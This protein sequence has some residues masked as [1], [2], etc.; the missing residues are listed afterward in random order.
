MH[1]F[2]CLVFYALCF[3]YCIICIS[4]QFNV[5]YALYSIHC[6]LCIVFHALNYTHNILCV[7]FYCILCIIFY[8]LCS[9][10]C[11]NM[12]YS[13]HDILWMYS[14]HFILCIAFYARREGKRGI[15][16]KKNNKNRGLP[17]LL[18]WSLALSSDQNTKN[19]GLS[20]LLC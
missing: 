3:I 19:S 6:I 7:V 15:K 12:L 20:K 13:M 10:Y 2:L 17:K 9:T 16:K 5:F 11:I 8:T 14:V 1:C 18:R 4:I